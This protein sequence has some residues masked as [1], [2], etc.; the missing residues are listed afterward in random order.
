VNASLA[1]RFSTFML[2]EISQMQRL[3][4]FLGHP[5]Y[6]LSVVLFALLLAS[7]VSSAASGRLTRDDPARGV[8]AATGILAPGLLHL[9]QNATTPLRIGVAV[10]MLLP[11]GFAMGTAFPLGM[12]LALERAPTLAPWLWGNQRGDLGVRVG[13]RRRDRARLGHLDGLLGGRDV[14]RDRVRRCTGNEAA[15]LAPAPSVPGVTPVR[16][17]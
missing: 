17:R 14:L 2:I 1:P 7:G 3:I 10:A 16:P 9:F 11:L 4:I 15:A 5:T 6:S 12:R 13:P 8:L